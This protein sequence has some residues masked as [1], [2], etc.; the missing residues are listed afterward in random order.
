MAAVLQVPSL[1][2]FLQVEEEAEV[3]QVQSLVLR[4]EVPEEE[5]V[6]VVVVVHHLMEVGVEEAVAGVQMT[7][8]KQIQV[9]THKAT[10]LFPSDLF[11]MTRTQDRLKKAAQLGKNSA[12]LKRFHREMNLYLESALRAKKNY[13]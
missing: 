6:V 7:L 2:S 10:G 9:H 8:L 4:F 3:V 13:L 5:E 11:L 12:T 1:L